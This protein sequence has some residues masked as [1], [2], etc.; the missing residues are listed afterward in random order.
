ME[1][2]KKHC[3]FGTYTFGTQFPNKSNVLIGYKNKANST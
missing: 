1:V 2:V 3:T